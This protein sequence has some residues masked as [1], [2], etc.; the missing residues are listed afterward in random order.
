MIRPLFPYYGSKWNIARY[1][2]APLYSEVVEPFAGSA[3]YSLFYGVS[4]AWLVDADP[5]IANLWAYLIKVSEAEIM[6]LPE[7]PNAGDNVNNYALP[8][9]AK[10]L[11]GFWINRGSPKPKNIR[12][13]Y[14]TRTDK[15]QLTWG[16][17]AKERI[18]SSLHRIRDWRV[19][20]D[21]FCNLDNVAATWFIDPPYQDKGK[22]YNVKFCRFGELGTWA[23][24]RTG[25]VIVCEG[26]GASWLPFKPLGSFKTST[27]R[28]DELV[29]LS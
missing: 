8:Q 11:I 9:E 13:A 18:A 23:L 29:Y 15:A 17:K 28:A 24:N 16:P 5:I 7:L 20:Q 12:T 1:Y 3:G 6:A 26:N 19:K 21:D 27:G 10:W 25:Q 2:P 4:R 22:H 14:S